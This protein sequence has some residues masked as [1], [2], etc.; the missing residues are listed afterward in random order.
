MREGKVVLPEVR[1]G[2]GI[3]I[4]KRRVC[5]GVL[6]EGRNYDDGFANCGNISMFDITIVRFF[7][8][9]YKQVT[10]FFLL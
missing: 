7:I 2:G 9:F 6:A 3:H 8:L 10:T 1:G 4:P 5:P